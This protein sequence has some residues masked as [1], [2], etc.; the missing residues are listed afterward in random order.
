MGIVRAILAR[1]IRF[2]IDGLQGPTNEQARELLEARVEELGARCVDLESR[3]ERTSEV[4]RIVHAALTDAKVPTS[5]DIVSRVRQ[6]AA[7]RDDALARIA[8]LGA[9]LPEAEEYELLKSYDDARESARRAWAQNGGV[10]DGHARGIRAVA[11]RVRR[12]RPQCLIARA[13]AGG[14]NVMVIKEGDWWFVQSSG[15]RGR[16][17]EDHIPAA[18]V[19]AELARQLTEVGA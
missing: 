7:M 3:S 13:V 15:D 6:L 17:N 16:V 2:G 11:E 4:I 10:I 18:E 1:A 14:A 5:I 9:P 12:E 8:E 19:P